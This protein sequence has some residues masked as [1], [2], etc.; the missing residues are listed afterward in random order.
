MR[1]LAAIFDLDGTLLNT[2]DDLADA[3]N[4]ALAACG[5]PQHPDVEKHKYF[6]GD[7]VLNYV[8]RALPPEKRSDRELIARVTKTYRAA[9]A[10][11]YNVKTRPYDGIVPTIEAMRK[12]GIRCAVLSNKPD[13]ATAATV[14]EFIGLEHFDLV[15]GAMENVPLKPDP[16]SALSIARDMGIAP[17]DFAYIG[18]T[19]TDMQTAVAAGMYPIGALWGFRKADELVGAGAKVLIEKPADLLKCLL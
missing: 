19:A 4:S 9:Y 6:V 11:N 8:L 13:D 12:A 5:L 3:M 2:I 17:K 14:A 18:D 15:R 1:F 10:K 16:S 7:G